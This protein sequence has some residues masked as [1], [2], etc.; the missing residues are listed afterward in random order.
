MIPD[1]SVPASAPAPVPDVA[2]LEAWLRK[3]IAGVLELDA[4]QVD[5]HKP[6]AK[7][8]VDSTEVVGMIAD[9]EVWLGRELPLDIVWEWATTREVAQRIAD[10]VAGGDGPEASF[11]DGGEHRFR[12]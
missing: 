10:H 8:G 1:P 9:L 3:A 5:V 6:I 12:P 7:Y 2:A 11:L 4:R